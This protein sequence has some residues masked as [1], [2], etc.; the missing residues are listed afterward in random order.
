MLTHLID[1]AILEKKPDQVLHWYDQPPKSGF[2]G[3]GFHEDKIA[4]A[5]QT[6][7][8]DRA[9]AIWKQMAE[10][11][12]A[13]TK[14]KAYEEAVQYL[15]KAGAVMANQKKKTN[16][17]QYLQALRQEHAR[18]RRFLDTLSGLDKEPI[19]KKKQ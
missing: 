2:L 6:H 8:P 19:I 1:I 18:K 16:W 14:P 5:V 4:T 10:K 11:L 17:S 12:I 9:V 3:Y 15:R 7:A 13:Q